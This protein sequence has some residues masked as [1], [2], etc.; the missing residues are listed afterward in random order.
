MYNRKQIFEG[1]ENEFYLFDVG[2]VTSLLNREKIDY[3]TD[4]RAK[5]L[6]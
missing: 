6:C 2:I 5:S 3:G 1:A 4:K